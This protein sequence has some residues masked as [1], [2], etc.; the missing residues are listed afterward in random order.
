MSE[1]K[2]EPRMTRCEQASTCDE[3]DGYGY[4]DEDGRGTPDETADRCERCNGR[5]SVDD[6]KVSP[7]GD[8]DPD[9]DA[10]WCETYEEAKAEVDALRKAQGVK[11]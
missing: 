10:F 4:L 6:W 11:S 9:R 5:G 7:Y 8:A 3:C 1:W 2:N